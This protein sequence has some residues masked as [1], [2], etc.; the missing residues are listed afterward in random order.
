MVRERDIV[1][2]RRVSDEMLAD[3]LMVRMGARCSAA[4]ADTAGLAG[5]RADARA[6]VDDGGASTRKDEDAGTRAEE[7]SEETGTFTT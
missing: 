1:L 2:R 4:A 3:A 5:T 7:A 6:S